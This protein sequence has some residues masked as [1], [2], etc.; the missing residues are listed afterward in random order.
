MAEKRNRK[1][2]GGA[3]TPEDQK[4]SLS[5]KFTEIAEKIGE[6]VGK[7]VPERLLPTVFVG[8]ALVTFLFFIL[9]IVGFAR[10]P[11]EVAQ[12]DIEALETKVVKLEEDL[13]E[14]RGAKKEA[15]R[16]AATFERDLKQ[17]KHKLSRLE[18]NRGRIN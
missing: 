6:I 7:V 11:E 9:M 1:E 15:E 2:S 5:D 3:A 17:A 13:G 18:E 12:G 16:S 10:D 8:T 4:G 14:T